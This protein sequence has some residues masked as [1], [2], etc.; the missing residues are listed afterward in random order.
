MK[1]KLYR[2]RLAAISAEKQYSLEE[3]VKCLK[4]MPTAKFDET[5]EVAFRL[6]IDA[7]QSDQ[8]IRGAIV[9]PKGTGKSLKVVVAA[10]GDAAAAAKEAG[11]DFVGYEDLVQKIQGGW[12]DFDV[13]IATPATMKSIR[14]LG[15]QLGPRGLMPNPKTGTVTDDVATAVKEAK[16]GRVEYRN[17]KAGV[18]HVVAGKLSFTEEALIE[19]INAI[20]DVIRRARPAASKG[21]YMLGVSLC[22]TMSPGIRM[23]VRSFAKV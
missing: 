1:S 16:A 18:V 13:L 14:T 19:N 9:L 3:A 11:A 10:E 7:R 21:T 22:A 23:D 17:D 15:R 2:S 5:V 6:G 8:N 4:S 20:A 12:L